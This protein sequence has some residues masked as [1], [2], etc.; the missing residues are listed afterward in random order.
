MLV[1]ENILFNPFKH[2]LKTIKKEIFQFEE[3]EFKKMLL[4]IGNSQM[5]LYIGNLE[6]DEIKQEIIL[7]LKKHNLTTKFLFI[8]YLKLNQNYFSVKISDNSVWVMRE[9]RDESRFVHIHPARYSPETLR[10]KANT[11]KTALVASRLLT[12]EERNLQNI[13]TLRKKILG[14]SPIKDIEES[15]MISK[16]IQIIE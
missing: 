3:E 10:V 11:L 2:H 12:I 7:K 5:D 4:K 6:I 14:L 13:N 16:M 8:N 9:G 1:I 15:Q